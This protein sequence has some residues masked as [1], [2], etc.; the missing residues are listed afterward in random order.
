MSLGGPAHCWLAVMYQDI[1]QYV[2]IGA[3][4]NAYIWL[5]GPQ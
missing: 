3:N 5:W 4:D 1:L 2:A